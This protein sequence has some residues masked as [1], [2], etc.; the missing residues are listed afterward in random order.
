[1]A[2]LKELQ[3]AIERNNQA[4][5]AAVESALEFKVTLE[6]LDDAARAEPVVPARTGMPSSV[7]LRQIVVDPIAVARAIAQE[8]EEMFFK[9]LTP[10]G[11]FV[12]FDVGGAVTTYVRDEL[13]DPIARVDWISRSD[14]FKY[15]LRIYSPMCAAHMGGLGAE[16]DIQ[17]QVLMEAPSV[18]ELVLDHAKRLVD[19]LLSEEERLRP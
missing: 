10:P 6:Q 9:P 5:A 14:T 16:V 3:A 13:A 11:K 18:E 15:T 17:Q 2:D 8:I 19:W 7:L 12:L 1:M 4:I